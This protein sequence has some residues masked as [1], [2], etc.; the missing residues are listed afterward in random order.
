MA[1]KKPNGKAT[2]SADALTLLIEDHDN[3]RA[4]FK[5]YERMSQAGAKTEERNALAAVICAELT[6]HAQIE[7]EIFYPAVRGTLEDKELIDEALVEHSSAKELISQLAGMEAKDQLFDAKVK[8]LGEQ[9]DHHVEE[10]ENEM[11]PQIKK[12]D[13]DLENLGARLLARKQELL[14]QLDIPAES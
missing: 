13:L 8:V 11:F 10:E 5:K 4:M 9:I 3:V 7:E 6:M 1:A 14:E 12:S 2:K